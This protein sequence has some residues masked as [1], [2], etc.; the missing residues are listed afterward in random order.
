MIRGHDKPRLMG[1]AIAILL[2]D[3]LGPTEAY[4]K[5]KLLEGKTLGCFSMLDKHC[6]S[7]FRSVSESDIWI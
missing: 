5:L 6:V 2:G 3:F 7:I 4:D 1:V